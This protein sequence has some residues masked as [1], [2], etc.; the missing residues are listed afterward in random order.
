M[1][2]AMTVGRLSGFWRSLLTGEAAIK[3]GYSFRERLWGMLITVKPRFALMVTPVNAASAAVLAYGGYPSLTKCI[4]GLLSVA[5]VSASTIVF[6][7]IVDRKRDVLCWPKRSLPSGR[8]RLMPALALAL[9]LLAGSL[10]LTW[11]A[12]NPLAFFILLSVF[13][14]GILYAL[15]LRRK[16]GYLALPPIVGLIYLGGWA[17]F[18]PET[19]FS[20]R[21]PWL[22]YL[23]GVLWQAA[24]IMVYSPLHPLYTEQG[25]LRTESKALFAA[26][27]PRTAVALGMGFLALTVL[28]SGL[29]PLFTGLSFVYLPLTIIAG[30][31]SLVRTTRFLR[32]PTDKE[33]GFR[34]FSAVSTLRT[35]ISGAILLDVLFLWK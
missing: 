34:A 17:A 9:I 28:L 31:W 27:S 1:K 15:Y 14:L 18:S 26:T 16:V 4:L 35:V 6:N 19:L 25:Q 5:F 2:A 30:G 33:V 13:A 22:L 11:L 10:V 12:F 32:Q 7:D 3:A 23:L 21:L 24:H 29:L 20:A 8:V